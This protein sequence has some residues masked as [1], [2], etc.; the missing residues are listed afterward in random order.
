MEHPVRINSQADHYTMMSLPKGRNVIFLFKWLFFFFTLNILDIL[1]SFQQNYFKST[2]GYKSK[3]NS[4]HLNE[5]M[6]W[7][8]SQFWNPSFL[9]KDDKISDTLGIRNRERKESSKSGES[10]KEY[11]K[12]NLSSQSDMEIDSLQSPRNFKES[13]NKLNIKD[14]SKSDYKPER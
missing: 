9:H 6:Q 8:D 13:F 3:W 1:T 7:G 12:S 10:Q 2:P 5:T 11:L 14:S 4:S